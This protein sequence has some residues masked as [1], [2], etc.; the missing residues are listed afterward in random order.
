MSW[1]VPVLDIPYRWNQRVALCVW[2]LALSILF[3]RFIHFVA[4]VSTSFLILVWKGSMV[5]TN[6]NWLLMATRVASTLDIV[7]GADTT[8]RGHAFV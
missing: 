1:H 5:W 6:P 4:S 7:N 8:V 2:I 3:L